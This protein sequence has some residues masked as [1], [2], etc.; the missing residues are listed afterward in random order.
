MRYKINKYYRSLSTFDVEDNT[1]KKGIDYQLVD[2]SRE[3]GFNLYFLKNP[4]GKIL[5]FGDLEF[6]FEEN[7]RLIE[8]ERVRLINTLL[9][10][11]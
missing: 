4:F 3:E 11:D 9:Y 5:I 1:F 10:E 6:N 7:F 8:E 2:V